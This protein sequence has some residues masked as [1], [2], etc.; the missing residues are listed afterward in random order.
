[1]NLIER[2]FPEGATLP[3]VDTTMG[4]GSGSLARLVRVFVSRVAVALSAAS[5]ASSTPSYQNTVRVLRQPT[6][7]RVMRSM[8]EDAGLKEH[9]VSFD[10][11]TVQKDRTFVTRSF[12]S[13]LGEGWRIASLLVLATD[14]QVMLNQQRSYGDIEISAVVSTDCSCL[15]P[16]THFFLS[17]T[18]PMESTDKALPYNYLGVQA[19]PP[20]KKGRDRRRLNKA[21]NRKEEEDDT[22]AVVVEEPITVIDDPFSPAVEEWE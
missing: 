11:F 18:Y 5:S 3:L 8:L 22:N 1:M 7:A 17:L 20:R 10:A 6:K 21:L 19:L 13:L 4:I 2:S 16:E 15:L 9:S 12:Y 14:N